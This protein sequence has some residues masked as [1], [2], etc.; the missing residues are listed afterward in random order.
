MMS[1]LLMIQPFQNEKFRQKFLLLANTVNN[2]KLVYFD[3]AATTQK[4]SSTVNA[5]QHYYNNDNA[6][7]HRGSYALSAN[8]TQLFEN[9][10]QEVKSFINAAFVNE[11][12]WTKGAT[13]AINLVANSWGRKYL[14]AGDEIVLSHSEHHANI[15]PWQQIAQATGAIIKVLPLCDDG[16]IDVSQLDNFISSKTRIVCCTHISNVIGKINDIPTIIAK[17]KSV[18]AVTL[19]DGA[20]AVAHISVNV[21]A[22]NCD[23]YVFSAHKV[24]GPTGL[25]VLYGKAALLDAMPPYQSGGEMVKKVSF[26][27][28][29]FNQLPYKFEAGTPNIAA[30][31]GFNETL[32]QLKKINTVERHSYEKELTQYAYAGLSQIKGLVFVV[33][34]QPDIGIFS[35]TLTHHHNQDVAAFLDSKGIAVRNGHHCAM[36]LMEHLNLAGCVRVSLTAYNT[37]E[38]VDYLLAMLTELV[39][40][41]T[42]QS[43]PSTVLLPATCLINEITA[44]LKGAKSWD[45]KHRQIMLYGNSLNRLANNACNELSLIE[46]CESKAWLTHSVDEN[47]LFSFSANS[48]AKIIRGLLFIT[49]SF[50]QNLSA[51]KIIEANIEE[52][53]E[54]LG[55]LQHLSP[56]R[57]N[58][59][60]SIVDKIK[61]IAA[62]SL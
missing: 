4:M 29:T 30:V 45:A 31:I 62:T 37:V 5:I 33:K 52:Y 47:G 44:N 3:N 27:G 55:L 48:D 61:K 38:E 40:D 34:H 6:N 2:K 20:Q 7:V 54:T 15:V 8:A 10:R 11:I 18:N 12:I 53:F 24:Y 41:K 56:S 19:I 39:A 16:T 35:F 25:G 32:N 14:K 36:P 49:T 46:G 26:S 13:E 51:S 57:G 17:A 28:T 9:A 22:L 43:D 1:L 23:F 60:R 42:E 58:G 59:L 50:Y 21:Q